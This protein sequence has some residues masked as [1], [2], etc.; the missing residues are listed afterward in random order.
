[1][2]V[3]AGGSPAQRVK[4]RWGY[5]ARG[6]VIARRAT[7]RRGNLRECVRGIATTLAGSR[8]DMMGSSCTGAPGRRALR[9]GCDRSVVGHD[10]LG[11]PFREAADSTDVRVCA[12]AVVPARGGDMSPPY[13][14]FAID[15]CRDRACPIRSAKRRTVQTCGFVRRRSFLHAAGTCPRPTGCCIRLPRPLRGLAMTWEGVPARGAPGRRALR[16]C[17]PRNDIEGVIRRIRRT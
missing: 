15:I 13:R 2:P 9:S 12:Q 16:L 10:D 6:R 14:R 3:R 8:N 1:M 11:V 4:L 7:A 5:R 17:K